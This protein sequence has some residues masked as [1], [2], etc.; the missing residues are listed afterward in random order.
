MIN[1]KIEYLNT[2]Q[3]LETQSQMK[4]V[5]T[6][7]TALL[8]GVLDFAGKKYLL[9]LTDFNSFVIAGKKFTFANDYDTY[10]SYVYNYK[11]VSLLE[12]IFI[13]NSGN[14]KYDFKNKNPCDLRRSNVE[15]YHQ[16]HDEVVKQNYTILEYIQGHYYSVGNDAFVLKNP[17]WKIRTSTNEERILMYCEKNTLCILSA[18]SYLKII[19]FENKYNNGKKITFYKHLNGY[20]CCALNLFIHQIIMDC[21]GN[22]KGTKNISVDHIDRDPLNNMLT[23]LKVATREEQE[24]NT[25]G[26]ATDTKRARKHNAQDLPEGLTQLMMR[27]YVVYYNECYNKEKDLY[28]EFFK[29]EKHPKLDKPWISSKSAKVSRADKLA[30]VNKVV[31]DLERDIYPESKETGLPAFVSIKIERDKPHLIFDQRLDGADGGATSTTL[32]RLNLRMVM[33]TDYNLEEQLSIFREK[34][35]EKYEIELL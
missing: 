15:I 8:C 20:I 12:N 17:M 5:P 21:R 19:E 16:Y 32:K 9:D 6:V 24:Q 33:P 11:R 28:R 31:A 35:K 23:N 18:D 13:Y 27:K 2:A 3:P 22:G 7:D 26:I 29:V 30:S 14:I 1:G 10:P 25:R 34:I 4:V